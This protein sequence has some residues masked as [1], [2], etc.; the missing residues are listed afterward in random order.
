MATTLIYG[1]GPVEV[2]LQINNQTYTLEVSPS[3][4]LAMV[5]RDDLGLTG[6]KV[7]CGMGNCGACT[8]W[9]DGVPVYSCLT[10]ALD[11]VGRHVTTIEGLPRDGEL[12]PVQQ[13]FIAEDAFQCAYCTSGQVMSVAACLEKNPNADAETI[14][15]A[16]YG[17]LCRCGAYQKIVRAGL[18]AAEMMKVEQARHGFEHA[19]TH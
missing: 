15:H 3:Q 6:T 12:H 17:N 7:A 9:L 19:E 2:K 11:C 14:K 13:A 1:P 4:N 10:L 5:L 16:V 18:K 8:V